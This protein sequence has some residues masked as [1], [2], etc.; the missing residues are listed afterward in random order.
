MF[1][2]T[3]TIWPDTILF[4]PKL[5]TYRKFNTFGTEDRSIIYLVHV[6]TTTFTPGAI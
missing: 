1:Q 6:K 4:K 3:K 2:K 5:R